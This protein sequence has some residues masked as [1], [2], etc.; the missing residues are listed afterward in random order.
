MQQAD[1]HRYALII[2]FDQTVRHGDIAQPLNLSIR[3]VDR[4]RGKSSEIKCK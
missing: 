1:G 4:L 3:P 2:R